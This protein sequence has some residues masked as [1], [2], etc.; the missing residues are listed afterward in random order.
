MKNSWTNTIS[1]F[2]RIKV[3]GK[4][5][6]LFLNRC[7]RENVSIWHIRRVGDET[8]VC[9]VALED[10]KRLRP[11]VKETKVKLYFIERRGMPFFVKKM[12][13]RTGFVAGVLSFV[14]ILFILSNMVWDVSIE[15]A[16]PKVEYQLSQAVQ[17][18]G[19]KKGR[20]H[21]LLPSV[22]EIQM[23]VTSEIE[24]ATW[25]GV[26][27]N[28]T[29]YH[30][31]VV[32]QT[33]PE[34]QEPIPPRH[35]VSK[36]KAIIYDIFVEQGQGKV[37]PNDFVD[38]G[39]M[40]ISGFIGKEGKMEIAPAK[41]EIFGE[42]W[43]KSNVSIP[44]V[45]EF[46]TLTGENKKNYSLSIL[47]VNV[48]IWGFGKPEFTEYEINEYSSNFK[49]L[50]WVLPIKYNRK[51]FLEKETLIVEYSTEEARSLATQMA[52]EE[53]T[54]KLDEDA[55]IKR[56]KVLHETIENGKVKLMIHYQVI[57][58]IAISQPIIQGD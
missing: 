40:L 23:K 27:L 9:Y 18:L 20:F 16:S 17:E 42:V 47:N 21:F 3:V 30:F 1:G 26:T 13:S 54:K 57:E 7:I 45:S 35:L 58:D 55:V 25:I 43:Y 14:A 50:K 48:P 32:E 22:E 49:F 6:E 10:V 53:L 34:K 2:S 31:N 44:L 12:I 36:K 38:K 11:I 8:I 5:T 29:T 33:F 39:E 46:S 51:Y 52:R 15:G 24:E 56:E 37:V 41:G 4:Y 28:G 19:I